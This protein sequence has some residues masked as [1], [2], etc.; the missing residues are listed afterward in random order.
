MGHDNNR[1]AGDQIVTE[2]AIKSVFE[3]N[4][5]VRGYGVVHHRLVTELAR[6][7]WIE[8]IESHDGS[9]SRVG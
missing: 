2:P 8:T 3:T 5:S 1:K 7:L 4:Y 9:T 6:D